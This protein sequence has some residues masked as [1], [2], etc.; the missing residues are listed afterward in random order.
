M[1]KKKRSG[2]DLEEIEE[3]IKPANMCEFVRNH[4]AQLKLCKSTQ[5]ADRKKH[6][7]TK[8]A[9]NRRCVEMA[10]FTIADGT[11]DAEPALHFATQCEQ[12]RIHRVGF[13][14]TQTGDDEEPAGGAQTK[15]HNADEPEFDKDGKQDAG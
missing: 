9:D 8:P 11:G 3:R 6:N 4:G 12:A 15:K 5:G 14:A 1:I 2:C 7:L 10:R 13:A